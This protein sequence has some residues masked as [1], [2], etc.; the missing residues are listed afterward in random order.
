MFG[1]QL[2]IRLTDMKDGRANPKLIKM[3]LQ[4]KIR[5]M[6]KRVAIV[7]LRRDSVEVFRDGAFQWE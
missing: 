2:R 4:V 5:E 7:I 6:T 1:F 3:I